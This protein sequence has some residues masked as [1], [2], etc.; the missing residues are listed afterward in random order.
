MPTFRACGGRSP[1]HFYGSSA[2]DNVCWWQFKFNH[3]SVWLMSSGL[4]AANIIA[5]GSENNTT[6]KSRAN[7]IVLSQR[8]NKV[9]NQSI[10][11]PTSNVSA[12]NEAK[13]LIR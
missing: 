7:G 11:A 10:I 8:K 13:N 3:F 2:K 6:H 1:L 5:D 9:L 4:T 12:I